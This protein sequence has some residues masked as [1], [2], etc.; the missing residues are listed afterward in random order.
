CS[1]CLDGFSVATNA[2]ACSGWR[3][4]PAGT[5]VTV[6][7]SGS[8]DRQCGV[9]DDGFRTLTANAAQCIP[10]DF[11]S[12]GAQSFALQ[13][14][15]VIDSGSVSL[16]TA[17]GAV[18]YSTR[19]FEFFDAPS[20]LAAGDIYGR[21][22]EAEAGASKGT[23]TLYLP[24]GESSWD[25]YVPVL[26]AVP[27]VDAPEV[28]A[29]VSVAVGGE[30]GSLNYV[31]VGGEV[32]FERIAGALAFSATDVMLEGVDDG[33]IESFSTFYIVPE[34]ASLYYGP[35]PHM[36]ANAVSVGEPI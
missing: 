2:P 13:S 9:C 11:M 32:F 25:G 33:G 23:I 1:A 22:V 10:E 8:Q 26:D 18:A 28:F 27:D 6:E 19:R 21:G 12:V 20:W 31:G 15:W 29:L 3:D 34:Q 16:E 35:G 14:L 17:A 4:C 36:T 7:P 30:L 24:A 5:V